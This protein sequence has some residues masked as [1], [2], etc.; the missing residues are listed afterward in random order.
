MAERWTASSVESAQLTAVGDSIG[1]YFEDDTLV[2]P[3][4]ET[5]SLEPFDLR[6]SSPVDGTTSSQHCRNEDEALCHQD[7]WIDQQ[8]LQNNVSPDGTRDRRLHH[9]IDQARAAGYDSLDAVFREYY[10]AAFSSGSPLGVD[11]RLSRNRRLPGT[12]ASVGRNAQNWSA[13]ERRGLEEELVKC[14]EAVLIDECHAF[15]SSPQ[16]LECKE[17]FLKGN[18]EADDALHTFQDRVRAIH[19]LCYPRLTFS[20]SAP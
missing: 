17:A 12:I 11:Q 3:A 14:A 5:L 2:R 1:L 15:R 6:L 10:N 16:Y 8:N 20:S 18:E 13:W 9:V 4:A 7:R 19:A